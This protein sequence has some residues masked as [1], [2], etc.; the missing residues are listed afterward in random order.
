MEGV[1]LAAGYGSRLRSIASGPKFLID[2]NGKPLIYYP[3]YSMAKIGVNKVYVV[4]NYDNL[5]YILKFKNNLELNIDIRVVVNE[6]PQRGNGYSLYTARKVVRE[7]QFILSMSD[8]IYPAKV[9]EKV[10]EFKRIFAG[11]AE[12]VIGG[13][14]IPRFIDVDE[15][16]KILA[17]NEFNLINIGKDLVN[18]THIDIGVFMMSRNV[19]YYAAEYFRNYFEAELSKLIK[20]LKDRGL[21]V[22][23]CDIE[24]VPWKDIDTPEDLYM[25]LMGEYR[26]VLNIW[27]RGV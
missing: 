8:H 17:D 5:E 19:F 25:V 7:D 4:V 24:G 1:I 9:L 2:I 6:E 16:T 12:V 22:K 13:D 26:E 10:I 20:W 23:V 18:Y 11:D 21:R 3:L 27:E 14:S 15:A